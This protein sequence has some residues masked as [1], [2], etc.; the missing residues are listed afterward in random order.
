[1]N[2]VAEVYRLTKYERAR[3]LGLRATQLSKGAPPMVDTTGLHDV[4]RIA[5][6]E[7]RENKL[8]LIIRRPNADGTHVDVKVSEM[9]ID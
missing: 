8:P 6:K 7:L 2:K 1:M 5:E 3:V 9:I 4:L